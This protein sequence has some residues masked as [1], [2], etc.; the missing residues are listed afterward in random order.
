MAELLDPKV[1]KEMVLRIRAEARKL[2]KKDAGVGAGIKDLDR[3]VKDLAD[4]I[5]EVGR[6]DILTAKLRVLEAERKQLSELRHKSKTGDFVTV[7]HHMN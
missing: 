6:S 4:T 3:Q 1:T 2:G 7:A 5:Y